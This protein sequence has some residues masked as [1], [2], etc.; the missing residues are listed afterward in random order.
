MT[1]GG[2]GISGVF[3]RIPLMLKTCGN[4]DDAL[5]HDGDDRIPLMPKTCGNG[6]DDEH[7]SYSALRVC[8][9]GRKMMI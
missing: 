3:Y 6:D 1:Y 9:D 8:D 5:V 4:D 2:E 7:L